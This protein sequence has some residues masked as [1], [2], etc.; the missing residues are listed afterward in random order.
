M[1]RRKNVLLT[2]I[3]A[4]MISAFA[5]LL[6]SCQ[7]KTTSNN[8]DNMFVEVGRST[9]YPNVTI[10]VDRDTKVMYSMS[11]YDRNA[12]ILT[13]LV[14]ADGTPKIWKDSN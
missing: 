13:L 14:N 9:Q 11:K 4:I 7:S 2:F 5:L 10:L 12:G 6:C 1:L 8:I 3:C